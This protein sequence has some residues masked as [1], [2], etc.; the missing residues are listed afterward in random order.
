MDDK[1]K[2]LKVAVASYGDPR[3][4]STWSGI[5]A[6]IIAELEKQHFEVISIA[7][8]VPVEPWYYNW[9]RRWHWRVSKKWFLSSVD[10]KFLEDIGRQM[11]WHVQQNNPDIVLTIY[12]DILAYV[13]FSQPAC[14]VHDATFAGVLNYY[15]SF[16][17]LTDRS[18]RSGNDMYRRALLR[19]DAAVFSSEWASKSAIN[20]YSASPEKVF[21]IPLGAN[22][23]HIPSN[24]EVGAWKTKR[25]ESVECNLLFVGVDWE[26]KGG[27]FALR[28]V[29]E[30][31]KLKIKAHLTIVGVDPDIPAHQ[32]S[33]AKKVGFLDKKKPSDVEEF[34]KLFFEASA[35]LLPSE[36]EC[37][38][39]VY[40]EANAFGLPALGRDTGGVGEIIKDNING[41]LVGESES[42]EDFAKRWAGLWM[43]KKKYAEMLNLSRIE[44]EQ[45]LNYEV[46][47]KNLTEVFENI[48]Y[49]HTY[50]N[51]KKNIKIE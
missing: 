11:D 18:E 8:K 26:R 29:E 7:L 35:L 1:P 27:P 14:S 3:S 41:L 31:N 34:N 5:P 30:L 4:V 9:L 44:F 16:T 10:K 23:N 28:F 46:F 2:K 47:V 50:G 25:L 36:A 6:H 12:A 33:Y 40:C 13:T 32:L 43:D 45:R 21:T 48:I 51:T 49:L 42:A 37:Y 20:D 22:I 38:G 15:T 39:C 24:E 19:A 17:S